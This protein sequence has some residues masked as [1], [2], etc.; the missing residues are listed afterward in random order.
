MDG[1]ESVEEDLVL[2]AKL[3]WKPVKILEDKG[4]AIALRRFWYMKAAE[5]GS[6]EVYGGAYGGGLKRR[7]EHVG[8][9]KSEVVWGLMEGE[10][11]L[12]RWRWK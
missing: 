6:C 1:F 4:N 7:E 10:R 5:I 11:F 9:D 12:M 2:N 3:S 8:G